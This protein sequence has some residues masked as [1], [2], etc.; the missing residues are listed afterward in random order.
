MQ[1]EIGRIINRLVKN[2]FQHSEN[3]VISVNNLTEKNVLQQNSSVEGSIPEYST[4]DVLNRGIRD[5][6]DEEAVLE[7]NRILDKKIPR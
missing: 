5:M 1:K 7:I 4:P 3:L 2:R 6:S